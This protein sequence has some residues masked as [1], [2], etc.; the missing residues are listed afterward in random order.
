MLP[1]VNGRPHHPIYSFTDASVG[2][3]IPT[4]FNGLTPNIPIY[5]SSNIPGF[6]QQVPL[7]WLSC[8]LGASPSCPR[9]VPV[10]PRG[11]R[12]KAAAC[13][14]ENTCPTGLRDRAAGRRSSV[15]E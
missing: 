14:T 3:S 9:R 10:V 5:F 7:C 15:Q 6:G 2:S 8:P 11:L 12:R 13:L 1:G 4:S